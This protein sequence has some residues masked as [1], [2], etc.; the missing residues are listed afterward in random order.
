MMAISADLTL[1]NTVFEIVLRPCIL[2]SLK[3]SS[4]ELK[5]RQYDM[6]G[7]RV[8]IFIETTNMVCATLNQY[9]CE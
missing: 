5:N 6:C 9:L 1:F 4:V 7:A 3:R 2:Y 8:D